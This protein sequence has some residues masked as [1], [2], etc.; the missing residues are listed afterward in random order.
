MLFPLVP[1]N[2]LKSASDSLSQHLGSSNLSDK[3]PCKRLE[4]EMNDIVNQIIFEGLECQCGGGG[5]RGGR[6]PRSS[7]IPSIHS[8]CV[9]WPL[10]VGNC[11]FPKG[12]DSPGGGLRSET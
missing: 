10:L 3:A 8:K 1:P 5:K 4:K 12:F 11:I 2:Q 6:D 7:V 9:P